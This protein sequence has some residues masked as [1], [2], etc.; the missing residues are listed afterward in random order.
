[1]SIRIAQI[2]SHNYYKQF[3]RRTT[4]EEMRNFYKNIFTK[5]EP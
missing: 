5:T 3:I 1:M 2:L 4:Y